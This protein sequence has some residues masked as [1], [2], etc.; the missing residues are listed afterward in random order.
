MDISEYELLRELWRLE[1]LAAYEKI[2]L[3]SDHQKTLGIT[4]A[5]LK[6]NQSD[7]IRYISPDGQILKAKEATRYLYRQWIGLNEKRKQL[8]RELK[9]SKERR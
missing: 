6:L 1:D 3:I 5:S 4:I 7:H 9:E 2:T 8:I